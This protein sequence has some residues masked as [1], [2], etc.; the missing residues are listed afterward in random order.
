MNRRLLL[1][2]IGLFGLTHVQPV[3]AQDVS[4]LQRRLDALEA[5]VSR[6]ESNPFVAASTG[7]GQEHAKWKTPEA[8]EKLHVG[9]K[10]KEVVELLGKQTGG[11]RGNDGTTVLS[12]IDGQT[13]GVVYLQ[14]GL[15]YSWQ[16]PAL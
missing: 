3:L 11:Q 15:V 16:A 4:S 12:Y 7:G 9:M 1:L 14:R 6:I 2:A 13:M 5:R 10:E 8:W